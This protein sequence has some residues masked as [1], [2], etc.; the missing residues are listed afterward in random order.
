MRSRKPAVEGRFYPSGKSGIFEQIRKIESIQNY[1]EPTITP[2]RIFGAVLPHAGHIYSGH[3]TIP[4][5]QLMQHMKDWPETFV[6]VHP[7]HR[8][9]GLPL[10][11]DDAEMWKNSVGE[12]FIDRE[13]AEGLEL[14]FD[15]LAHA[16][17]HSAEV[18]IPYLQY[19]F[20]KHPFRIVPICM[21]EQDYNSSLKVSTAILASAELT[22]RRIMVLS[23]CDFSHFLPPEVG[24]EK[25]QKVI[26]EIVGKNPSGVE[27]AVKEN[28]VT[29]CGYGPIMVLM[30]YAGALSEDYHIRVLARGH[31]GEVV[32]SPEVVNYISMVMY[33]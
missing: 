11:I 12:V 33:Q 19:Y 17:E 23:S 7:N 27:R 2:N 16:Q 6:I 5:F 3:Q 31:S 32:S 8:G 15:R 18:I 9:H 22:G 21:G 26:D 1:P 14:P 4:F 13:F 30:N 29:I 28:H 24:R 20:P 10:A 25:D